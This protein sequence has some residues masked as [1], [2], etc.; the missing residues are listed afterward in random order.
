MKAIL[1]GSSLCVFNSNNSF[2]IENILRNNEWEYNCCDLIDRT[3]ER[4]HKV[5]EDAIEEIESRNKNLFKEIV[6]MRDRIVHSLQI[7][8]SGEH[9][10]LDF[11]LYK[12]MKMI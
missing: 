6:S 3:F 8:D 1:I 5:I 12:I 9:K 2:I 10:Y 4:L 11:L 7:M